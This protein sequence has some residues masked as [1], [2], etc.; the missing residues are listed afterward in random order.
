MSE[1]GE[2]RK[3]RIRVGDIVQ[4]NPELTKNPMFAGCLMAVT[5]VKSWGVQG[6]VQS[7]G[8]DMEPGGQAYYRATWETFEL[9]GGMVV[10]C[11]GH[12]GEKEEE[13]QWLPPEA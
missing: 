9:T 11:I 13:G 2:G 5:E 8:A 4:L 12:M 10:W 1:H 7:L 6:F 3:K